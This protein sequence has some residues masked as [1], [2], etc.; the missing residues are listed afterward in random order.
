MKI[1]PEMK[2]V[3]TKKGKNLRKNLEHLPKMMA[4]L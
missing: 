3:N 2:Y 1:V 4:V